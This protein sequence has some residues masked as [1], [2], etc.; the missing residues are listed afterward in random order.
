MASA[1]ANI[2]GLSIVRPTR[3]SGS[4]TMSSFGMKIPTIRTRSGGRSSG[5]GAKV[6]SS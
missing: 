4:G 3:S 1:F 2:A 6:S 5:V